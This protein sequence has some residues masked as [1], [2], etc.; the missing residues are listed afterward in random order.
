VDAFD[1][2]TVTADPRLREVIGYD[3]AAYPFPALVADLFGTPHLDRLHE[4]H[5]KPVNAT[6]DQDTPAHQVFYKAFEGIRPLYE[7]FLREVVA[8]AYDDDLCVQRIP[9]FRIHYPG[10]I[11]VREFH[12]DSD[13]HHQLGVMN[14]W[15]PLTP[16]FASN[17][18]WVESEPDAA[19]FAPVDLRPGQVLRFSAV[20][21]TH[22]NHTNDTPL[23]RVSFDFRVL[24]RSL[25]RDSELTSVTNGTRLTLGDYYALLTR[26][27][28][29]HHV[30][31]A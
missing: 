10:T 20:R 2:R 26:D 31:E 11:A 15:L 8:P 13:Y 22:G 7:R 30:G 16:A 19:D 29:L 12:R 24:P 6:G 17:T 4:R 27:G 5:P 18:I 9:T 1:E 28:E 21:L 23:T 14:Y 25:Y 3:L